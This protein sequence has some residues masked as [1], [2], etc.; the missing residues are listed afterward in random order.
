MT[1]K[2]GS[3]NHY[4]YRLVPP[5]GSE[6]TSLPLVLFGLAGTISGSVMAAVSMAYRSFAWALFFFLACAISCWFTLAWI[7][8]IRRGRRGHLRFTQNPNGV[9]LTASGALRAFET[10][11]PVVAT[12]ATVW[13][14]WQFMLGTAATDL[15]ALV[16]LILVTI[17]SWQ[18]I[19]T[20]GRRVTKPQVLAL[21]SSGVSLSGVL[22]LELPWDTFSTVTF[23]RKKG[24]VFITVQG[25]VR[26]NPA[27]LRCDPA[28]VADLIQYYK[29]HPEARPEPTDHRV[30]QRIRFH[31]FSPLMSPK[32]E[33]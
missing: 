3:Q 12:A 26:F 32:A 14:T 11:V 18:P 24:V 31:Q 30:S 22:E 27:D 19:I 2:D 33:A 25:S 9:A 1:S 4:V 16:A 8:V 29:D 15:R 13:L 10:L 5:A 21:T 17:V 6:G 23:D 7:A 20:G 28:L